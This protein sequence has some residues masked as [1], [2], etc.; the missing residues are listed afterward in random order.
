[1]LLQA[2][3]IANSTPNTDNAA[4]IYDLIIWKTTMPITATA[5]FKLPDTLPRDRAIELD[6]VEGVLVFRASQTVRE[7]I[8]NLLEKQISPGLTETEKTS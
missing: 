2:N 3:V 6:M 8:E 7:Q 5:S 1:M 4:S